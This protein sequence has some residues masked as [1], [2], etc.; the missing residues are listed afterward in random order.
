MNSAEH[1]ERL[2]RAEGMV[3]RGHSYENAARVSGAAP[4]T[5][6]AW[7]RRRGVESGQAQT[8]AF[9]RSLRAELERRRV[10]G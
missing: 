9:A 2:R 3:R 4:A 10:R 1:I 6:A 5:V 7:C 8:R